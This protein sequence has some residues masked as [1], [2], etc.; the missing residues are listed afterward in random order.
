MLFPAA[1]QGADRRAKIVLPRGHWPLCAAVLMISLSLSSTERYHWN[2]F[3]ARKQ[4]GFIASI[5]PIDN[6]VEH[7][8]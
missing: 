7:Y 2:G 1:A 8:I 3:P 4:G 6:F 5:H